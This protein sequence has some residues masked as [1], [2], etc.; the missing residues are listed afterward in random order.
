M[1]GRPPF[2]SRNHQ[3]LYSHIRE[4]A[5]CH[6]PVV[7][8][9]AAITIEINRLNSATDKI[10]TRGRGLL[11]RACGRN[12]IS[13]Y[14]VSEDAQKTGVS[15]FHHLTNMHRE[16]LEKWWFLTVITPLIPLIKIARRRR[17]L[18]R[19]RVLTGTIR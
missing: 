9:P 18:I 1:D 4:G 3:I 17:Y 8:A 12:V 13:C 15:D 2:H 11:N 16:I 7:S 19:F 6:Y 14:R 5:A 10:S